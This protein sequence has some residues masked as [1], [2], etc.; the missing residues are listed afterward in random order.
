MEKLKFEFSVT[1]RKNILLAIAALSLITIIS[2][3]HTPVRFWVN[4]LINNFYFTSLALSGMF[5]LALQFLTNT[6]WM[7]SYQVI[8]L[9]MSSYLPVAFIF[10][11]L[12]L[13][14]THTLYE[15]SHTEFVM[16]DPILVKKIAY[17]NTPFFVTRIIMYFLLW[18]A[19]SYVLQKLISKWK[20]SNKRILSSR[21]AAVSAF[22]MIT[23][24]LSFS[25]Y[26]Y[27][28]LMS[29]EPHWFSTIYSVYTFSSLFLG[30]IA[31]IT[32]SLIVLRNMGY[33]K[34]YVT[35]NH[36]HDLGKWL[37]GMSV[38]WAYIW[39]CQYMLI[40]Y[41]NIPEETSYYV[42]REHGNWNWLFW[43]NFVISFLFP[44]FIL[45][46]RESKRNLINLSVVAVIVLIGRWI[47]L[48]TLVA[49]K[50]YEHSHT[51]AII[52][53]YE[54]LSALLFALIFVYFFLRNLSANDLVIKE[55]PYLEEGRH[56]E[57]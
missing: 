13:F 23:F 17:L 28:S 34:E 44:F 29:L 4:L 43:S 24:A 40:W 18:L 16:N 47:D 31:F 49:P 35:R 50:V 54:I 1:L 2:F 39:F 52:G 19:F 42:L 41:S 15:W 48:F 56:L 53:P 12:G 26:S 9:A 45:L 46:T 33:L 36:F 3:F 38:F 10:T 14:G 25:F 8:P 21:L 30:G 37:F 7:R 20:G 55:D 5:F 51:E 22:T 32:L 27:D 11:I 57:Q 6:S